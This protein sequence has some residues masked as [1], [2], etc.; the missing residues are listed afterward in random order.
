MPDDQLEERWNRLVEEVKKEASERWGRML[1]PGLFEADFANLILRLRY[2]PN[3]DWCR[4]TFSRE[5]ILT[6]HPGQ[7]ARAF[8][9][10]YRAECESP[11]SGKT[12]TGPR[13]LRMM[14]EEDP[15]I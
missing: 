9:K 3:S 14:E 7:L 4:W 15:S 12:G 10:A 2:S 5:N 13:D 8:Y 11:G 6:D 1:D